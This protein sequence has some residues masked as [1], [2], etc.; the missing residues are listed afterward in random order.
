M[1]CTILFELSG[2][3]ETCTA[4]IRYRVLGVTPDEF[5]SRRD[6]MEPFM[7]DLGVLEMSL[8]TIDAGASRSPTGR[9]TT[10]DFCSQEARDKQGVIDAVLDLVRKHFGWTI[11]PK[12]ARA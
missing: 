4:R 10:W 2:Q 7:D 11:E 9:T 5:W 8:G 6:G 1:T 3:D 12:Q